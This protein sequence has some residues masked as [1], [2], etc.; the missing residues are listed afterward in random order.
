MYFDMNT[1][2]KYTNSQKHF[3]SYFLSFKD[4]NTRIELMHR[5]DILE[6]DGKKGITNGLTR[7]AI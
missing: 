4:T 6:H 5:P 2:E 7:F 1:S 3:S